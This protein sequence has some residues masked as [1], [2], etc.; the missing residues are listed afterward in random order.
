MDGFLKAA[1]KQGGESAWGSLG[2][3]LSGGSGGLPSV[4]GAFESLE[5]SPDMVTKFIPML[6]KFVQSKRDANVASLHAS[7]LM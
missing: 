3:A 4:A 5:L 1:P 2:S 7:A 6:T